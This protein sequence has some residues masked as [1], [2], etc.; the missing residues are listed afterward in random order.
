MSKWSHFLSSLKHFSGL[1]GTSQ[2]PMTLIHAI[3][4]IIDIYIQ[5]KN[6]NHM[7][8]EIIFVVSMRIQM[9][10]MNVIC[11]WLVSFHPGKCFDVVNTE[12]I[13]KCLDFAFFRHFCRWKGLISNFFRRIH[14]TFNLVIVMRTIIWLATYTD[15]HYNMKRRLHMQRCN[16]IV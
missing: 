16:E 10:W 12:V 11:V 9:A 7:S 8:Y 15:L 13:L 5:Q 2:T 3:L 4:I 14:S 6:D 1:N